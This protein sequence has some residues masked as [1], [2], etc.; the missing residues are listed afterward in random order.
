MVSA[1]GLQRLKDSLAQKSA[2]A[3]RYR[4]FGW[5][6]RLDDS[7]TLELIPMILRLEGGFDVAVETMHMRIVQV[8]Q[9]KETLSPELVMAGRI[10]LEA[11]EFDRRLNHDAHALEEVIEA[12]LDSADAIPIVEM[13]LARLREARA[14]YSL[15]FTEENRI[16]G[17]LFAAQPTRPAERPLCSGKTR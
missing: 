14:N 6:N 1:T 15:G 7:A 16:L 3:E 9:D 2:P 17:A 12:C 11:C 4:G 13:L 8:R 5:N 10:V